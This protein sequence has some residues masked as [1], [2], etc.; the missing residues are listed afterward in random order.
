MTDWGDLDFEP[1]QPTRIPV[2]QTISRAYSFA[3]GGFFRILGVMWLPYVVLIAVMAAV[4]TLI[5]SGVLPRSSGPPD[6]KNAIALGAFFLVASIL[7]FIQVEGVTLEALGERQGTKLLYF[8]LNKPVWLLV[9][10]LTITTALFAAAIIMLMLF[11][12]AVGALIRATGGALETTLDAKV[13]ISIATGIALTVF[14]CTFLYAA[15]RQFFLLAP[16]VVLEKRLGIERAWKLSGENFWRMLTIYVAAIAPLFI[17]NFAFMLA[18]PAVLGSAAFERNPMTKR[19][20]IH[21]TEFL[22]PYFLVLLTLLYGLVYGAQAFAYRA[23]VPAE[24]AE[25]VF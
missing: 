7:L 2:G 15:I 11:V 18:I 10:A 12:A 24:K 23:L 19:L 6:L 9:A 25:D 20:A 8:S 1:P 22:L 3:F 13:G 21:H 17:A 4:G 5:D 14:F 16:V